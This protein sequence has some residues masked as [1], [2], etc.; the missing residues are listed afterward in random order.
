[1]ADELEL[2]KVHYG[3]IMFSTTLGVSMSAG[4]TA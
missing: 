4:T 1:M 3:K 2:I